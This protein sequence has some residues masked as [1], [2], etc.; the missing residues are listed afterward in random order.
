MF[1][2]HK[3]VDDISLKDIQ[4]P[5]GSP[6]LDGAMYYAVF[7]KN[8]SPQFYS[9]R[10]SVKGGYP[11]RTKNIP[12]LASIK[13]PEYA[14][15]VIGL[16]LIHTGH[17][18]STIESHPAASGILNSLPPRA[19]ETQKLT[20]PIR[21]VPHDVVRPKLA[22]YKDKLN[23]LQKLV[24]K[25]NKPDIFYLPE[26][27]FG[28]KAIEKLI[29]RTKD[30]N[31]EGVIVTSLTKPESDNVRLKIKHKKTWNLK[32]KDIHQEYDKYGK[33]KNS[34]GALV[35]EDATGREVGEVG[36]GFN[37]DL[38][39]EIWKHPKAWKGALVQVKGMDPVRPGMKLKML[40]YNGLADGDID[41][42]P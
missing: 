4:D 23:Y 36:T 35:L 33:P 24:E 19:I 2:R 20:G 16:E 34:A 22:T 5:V 27:H 6:K 18:P 25:V 8:G 17:D 9:R 31:K 42:I 28:H 41:T 1:T 10:Q 40:V 3:Y 7:D 15:A 13:V 29:K 14:G 26:Y 21:A 32:V 38:R 11:N 39:N 12:H 37:R 30:D